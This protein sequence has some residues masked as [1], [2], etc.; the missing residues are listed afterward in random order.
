MSILFLMAGLTKATSQIE[1]L[2]SQMSWVNHFPEFMV[3]FIGIAELLGALGLLLPSILKIKPVL[4]IWAA[5]GLFAIMIF[6]SIF[7]FLHAEYNF[8]GINV[9]FAIFLGFIAWGRSKK[10]IIHAKA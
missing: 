3:R 2:Q 6:A 8:I 10:V 5:L 7:H 9:I 4:S 1:S